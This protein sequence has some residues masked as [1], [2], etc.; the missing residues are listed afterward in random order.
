MTN[1]AAPLLAAVTSGR[2]DQCARFLLRMK[3]TLW[4]VISV[5]VLVVESIWKVE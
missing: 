2:A 4:S 1:G 5:P 3:V